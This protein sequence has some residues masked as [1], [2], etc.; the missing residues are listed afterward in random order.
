MG[1][2]VSMFDPR[3]A[4]HSREQGMIML[5]FRFP[6][7]QEKIVDEHFDESSKNM[8]LRDAYYMGNQI[9]D[10]M[11]PPDDDED[12]EYYDEAH[13]AGDEW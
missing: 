1:E 4:A 7:S 2:G 12:D 11:T 13:F 6:K 10:M 8:V 9:F 3:V 5:A